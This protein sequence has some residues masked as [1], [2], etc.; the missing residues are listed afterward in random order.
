MFNSFFFQQLG[1]RRGGGGGSLTRKGGV[2][3]VGQGCQHQ[4]GGRAR[5]V[6]EAPEHGAIKEVADRGAV[7]EVAI[8][9]SVQRGSERDKM[10]R[11]CVSWVLKT[12]FMVF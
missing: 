12:V 11:E 1:Q 9:G 10:E 2:G 5:R 6:G 8:S 7:R 4:R 3:E